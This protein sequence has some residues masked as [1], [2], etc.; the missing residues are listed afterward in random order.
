[1]QKIS[2]KFGGKTYNQAGFSAISLLEYE[3]K[4]EEIYVRY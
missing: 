2:E 1:M 4:E 3:F